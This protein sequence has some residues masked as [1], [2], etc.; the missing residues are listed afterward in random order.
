M[1]DSMLGEILGFLY[2]IE[3]QKRGL[4]HAHII[5]FLK[6]HAKLCNSDKPF[7][8]LTIVF[9]GAFQQILSVILKGSRTQVVGA[10]IK[11]SILW[12]YITVLY[13]H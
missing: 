10:S 6:P 11:R 2:T 9:G 4:P 12:H 8:G 13:L 1:K 3:F 5:V 7:G